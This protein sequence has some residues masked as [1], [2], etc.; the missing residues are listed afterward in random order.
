MAA[1]G[2]ENFIDTVVSVWE[3]CARRLPLN[4]ANDLLDL[5]SVLTTILVNCHENPTNL[6]YFD[7][8]FGNKMVQVRSANIRHRAFR[9]ARV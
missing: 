8:K 3:R 6:K 4:S 1:F 5:Q 9:V 2:D 7:L